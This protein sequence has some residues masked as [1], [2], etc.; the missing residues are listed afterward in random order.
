MPR[1][2]LA[3]GLRSL[4]LL[5]D[6]RQRMARVAIFVLTTG[7]YFL[8][9]WLGLRLLSA[10]EGV[11]VF[12][13]ASGF[14]AGLA[15]IVTKPARL[16]IALGVATATIL[17]NLSERS[18]I[19]AIL[20]FGVCNAVECLLFVRLYHLFDRSK[21]QLESFGSVVA[22]LAATVAAVA[23]V[24]VPA[25][26]VINAL[27]L[28]QATAFYVWLKWVEV[29]V[30]GILTV[31]PII[32][33]M[34]SAFKARP[35]QMQLLEG[36]AA[37]S[38]AIVVGWSIFGI[39]PERMLN[40]TPAT[41]MLPLF[42]WLAARP[43]Q[44]FSAIALLGLSITVVL[45]AMSGE[46]RFGD[47][48]VL[49]EDRLM[50][51]QFAILT[52]ALALLTLSS[53]FGREKNVSAAL[54]SSEQRLQLAL[55][56]STIYAFDYDLAKGIVYRSGGMLDRLGFPSAGPISDYFEAMPPE[57]RAAFKAN[58]ALLN[59]TR[60][61]VNSKYRLKTLDGQMLLIQH[62]A[63]GVFDKQGKL[64]RIVGTCVD[65]TERET[66]RQALE[67]RERQLREA[68]EAGRVFAFDIDAET[69]SVRRSDNASEILGIPLEQARS[70]KRILQNWVKGTDLSILETV[71]AGSSPQAP[72]RREIL[73]FVR[74]DGRSLWLSIAAT[75]TYSAEGKFLRLNGLVRDITEM[76]S[77]DL[78]RS[79]LIEELDHRVKNAL[80]R[81]LAII[82]LS[83]EEQSDLESFIKGLEQRI[84]S[85]S[86]TQER[87]SSSKWSGVSVET[88]INDEL[89]PFKTAQ[90]C[91]V[92]G[93]DVV[94]EPRAAQAFSFTVHEL[95]T[96]ASKYGALA[97]PG[98]RVDVNWKLTEGAK[99][100]PM[101]ELTW[102]ETCQHEIEPPQ[103][104]SYGMTTIREILPWELQG[105]HVSVAFE[106]N[107]L[108]CGIVLPL[109]P[110][111]DRRFS[112]NGGEGT[113]I[114][115]G[116]PGV[117]EPAPTAL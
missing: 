36:V 114:A 74:P 96:N 61:G 3:D 18:N 58:E 11:A 57:D 33:L 35:S 112:P 66:A 7:C 73:R 97:R 50:R 51:A 2:I 79:Q 71:R 31:A 55:K 95:A 84:M 6:G 69:E 30:L 4:Q 75:S 72:F 47:G 19:P 23:V 67:D 117:D 48:A 8:L 78:R 93:P 20:T 46:G 109:L 98:G 65:I 27:G 113:V 89:E 108:V 14:A 80:N 41:V 81:M 70:N 62:S 88:L 16:P 77:A 39:E 13:P 37:V 34:P 56:S 53:L 38:V 107:G 44:L 63:E 111:V 103:R 28:A 10:H 24:A 92:S 40:V 110:Q 99:T 86:K 43:P 49:L 106:T 21:S 45:I 32:I 29:D 52:S 15:A 17:A 82:M 42:I 115:G 91:R 59:P 104:E 102:R 64:E 25:A 83:R 5:F 101:L 54:L 76:H 85:M 87:L 105:A 100:W 1:E 68:L 12:W 26:F 22:F 116:E 60:Q 94:L 90:N 9:G